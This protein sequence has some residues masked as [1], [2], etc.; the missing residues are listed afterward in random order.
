MVK[1][2]WEGSQGP[3]WMGLGPAHGLAVDICTW[4]LWQR[5]QAASSLQTPFCMSSAAIALQ[6]FLLDSSLGSF[7]FV[8]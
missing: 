6:P 8:I 1:G 3:L 7:C 2:A 5:E 4:P